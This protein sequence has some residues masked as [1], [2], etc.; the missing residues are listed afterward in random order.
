MQAV[1]WLDYVSDEM[2]L[3]SQCGIFPTDSTI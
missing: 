3:H 1:Y 2:P